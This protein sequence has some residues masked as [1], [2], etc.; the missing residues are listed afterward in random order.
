MKHEL[1]MTKPDY[2]IGD[3]PNKY[4]WFSWLEYVVSV[5]NP[6]FLV[7]TLKTSGKAN[8]NL[9]SWGLLLGEEGEYWS[10]MAIK[11]GQHTYENILSERGWCIDYPSYKDYPKCFEIIYSNGTS[12][13]EIIWDRGI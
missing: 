4:K 8:A 6:I 7:T 5:T 9:Q 12:V 10:L 13:D 1:E 3:W 11:K 2:L